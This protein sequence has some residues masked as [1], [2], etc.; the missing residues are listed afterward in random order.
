MNLPLGEYHA[1]LAGA[2]FADDVGRKAILA[3]LPLHAFGIVLAHDNHEADSLIENA[4][5]LRLLYAAELL[6]PGKDRRRL[7]AVAFDHDLASGRQHPWNVIDQA[8]ASNVGHAADDTL[9]RIVAQHV[10]DG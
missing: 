7:P 3:K 4:V 2:H 8:A 9:H 6:Q 10:L 1:W 5:H